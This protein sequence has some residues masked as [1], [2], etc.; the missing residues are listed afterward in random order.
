METANDIIIIWLVI[1]LVLMAVSLYLIVRPYFP[2][3]A[4]AYA[5]LWMMKWSHVIHP[6]DW[7]MTSWGIAVA[8]VLVIDML[9]PRNLARCT[10]GMTYIGIGAIV[11][12]MVGMTG[13]SYLWMVV[14][15]A[16]GVIAGGYVYARTPAGKPIG[17]PSAR[18][19]QYLCAKGFPAVVTATV[20]GI[21]FMLWII[22]QHPVAT[23]QYM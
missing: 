8:M 7:L 19:F 11:G 22:E 1:G 17:F 16:V 20:I 2:A 21:A 14:G 5:G 13:L 15:A 10:N 23:I 18:F 4:T 9:Q 3:S 6:A 12:M